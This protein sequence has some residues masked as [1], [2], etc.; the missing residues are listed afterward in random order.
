ME[1][2]KKVNLENGGVIIKSDGGSKKSPKF[3]YLKNYTRFKYHQL[4]KKQLFYSFTYFQN[5][6]VTIYRMIRMN[7]N[8]HIFALLILP[9]ILHVI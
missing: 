8:F 3:A 6:I 9:V 5:L 1:K 4:D 7:E 2:V